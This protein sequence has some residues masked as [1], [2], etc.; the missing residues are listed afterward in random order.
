MQALRYFNTEGCCKPNVHYMVP[1]DDRLAA[2]SKYS[3]KSFL[4]RTPLRAADRSG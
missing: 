1:L 3:T 2:I 4:P